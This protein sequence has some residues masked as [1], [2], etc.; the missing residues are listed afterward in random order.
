M[1]SWCIHGW[2]QQSTDRDQILA[3]LAQARQLGF[4]RYNLVKQGDCYW[5]CCATEQRYDMVAAVR[6]Y[7]TQ[8]AAVVIQLWA[9][10]L[11]VVAW[12]QQTLLGC[13]QFAADKHGI[14]NF[15]Y[16]TKQWLS[17]QHMN[18]QLVIAGSATLRLLEQSNLVQQAT[19]VAALPLDKSPKL[20]AL[21]S[22][23]QPPPWLRR[24]VVWRGLLAAS[25]II[26]LSA[27]WFWPAPPQPIA[28]MSTAQIS[29]P[30]VTEKIITGWQAE[31][32]AH[33]SDLLS[34]ISFLAGWRVVQWQ[35]NASGE[36]IQLQQTYGTQ[37]DLL[38]QLPDSRWQFGANLTAPELTRQPPATANIAP[39]LDAQNLA[40]ERS[41]VTAAELAQQLN[42][43]GFVVSKQA[44]ITTIQH[45]LFDPF[46]TNQ[47]PTF[48]QWLSAQPSAKVTAITATPAHLNWYLTITVEQ[49]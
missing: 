32:V 3:W 45:A 18:C 47:W 6:S 46:S 40:T 7:V 31:Q 48:M 1:N 10:Q 42:D 34:H 21:R 15:I 9:Q 8:N 13:W 30:V 2:R 20:A 22:I 33:V 39:A 49:P 5:L 16:V 23:R 37:A 14:Q 43:Y 44:Q 25:V 29:P 38:A 35:L 12:R 11:V 27:W 4:E 17:P 26:G 28:P 19:V 24:R 41:L 36:S